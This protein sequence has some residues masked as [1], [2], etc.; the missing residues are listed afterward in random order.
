MTDKGTKKFNKKI[1]AV[2]MAGGEGSRMK[3]DYKTEKL[4]LKIR[5]KRLI[6]YVI[7]ALN[8]STCFYKIVVCV[9]R[10]AIK[11]FKFLQNYSYNLDP[12]LE[13][14]E[15]YGKGYSTDLSFI[16]QHFFEY[17]IFIVSADLPLLSEIDILKILSKYDF[18]VT[19]QSIIFDKKIVDE[20]CIKPSMVF[21]YR[22]RN[23]CYSGIN[24]FNLK[25]RKNDCSLIREKYLIMNRIGIA[26]NVNEKKDLHIARNF[27]KS[28]DF[29]NMKKIY[30]NNSI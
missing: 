29:A 2:I 28:K 5:D 10:N 24:I 9:S 8:K 20:V 21:E 18:N 1:I 16:I 27:V 26:V 12:P 14:I 25:K 7:E 15:G 23:Y 13:I 30:N 19:C 17:I 22:K 11:T 4:L 6:E 3:R